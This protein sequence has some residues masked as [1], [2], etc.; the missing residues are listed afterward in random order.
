MASAS[1]LADGELADLGPGEERLGAHRHR[2]PGDHATLGRRSRSSVCCAS[3]TTAESIS[4]RSVRSRGKVMTWLRERGHPRLGADVG[5]ATALGQQQNP[6]PGGR[7]ERRGQQCGVGGRQVGDRGDTHAGKLFRGLRADA[8]QRVD[9]AVAHH[10][11]PVVLGEGVDPRRLAE[12]GRHL[13]PLLVVADADR[14]R[15]SR[16][17]GDDLA[18]LLGQ[19]ER[20]VDVGAD[21]RLIPP[22]HLDRMAEIAQQAHHLFG[23]LVVGGRCPGAGTSRR[24]TCAPR[25]AAACRRAH[26][27]PAPDT[28]RT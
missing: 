21:V 28:T 27:T 7:A 18:D 1:V 22:P 12:S 6:Q 25:C 17:R 10:R 20:V 9:L 3:S 5:V 13:G 26:R 2:H 23:G 16:P 4:A 15:Q 14:T 8:P 11:H 24:G 19:V